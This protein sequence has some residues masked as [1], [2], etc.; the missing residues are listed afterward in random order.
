[1]AIQWSADQAWKAE[2]EPIRT[3]IAEDKRRIAGGVEKEIAVGLIGPGT[4]SR[5]TRPTSL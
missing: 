2:E 1:M 5:P 3:A 4:N